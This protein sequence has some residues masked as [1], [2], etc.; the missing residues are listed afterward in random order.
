[1]KILISSR[2][3]SAYQTNDYAKYYVKEKLDK[4]SMMLDD[5]DQKLEDA[6]KLYNKTSDSEPHPESDYAEGASAA[7]GYARKQIDFIDDRIDDYLDD[8][9]LS[10]L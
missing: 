5:A 8:Y 10:Y 3:S 4:V 7:M 2:Q 6:Q 1:M 9:N